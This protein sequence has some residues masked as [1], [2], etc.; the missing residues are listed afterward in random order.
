MVI[1]TGTKGTPLREIL[2]KLGNKQY[3]YIECRCKWIDKTGSHDEFFGACEYDTKTG[4]L[5]ALDGD[6]YSLNDLYIK[7]METALDGKLILTVWEEGHME[8]SND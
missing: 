3:E 4:N 7:W 2:A 5:K 6:S 1:I 8:T